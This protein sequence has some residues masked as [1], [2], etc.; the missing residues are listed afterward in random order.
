MGGTNVGTKDNCIELGLEMARL[1]YATSE[2]LEKSLPPV[3]TS[4]D[5][6]AEK[7]TMAGLLV[8]VSTIVVMSV[9]RQHGGGPQYA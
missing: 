6:P 9:K 5:N 8:L 3:G 4:V 1:S 7:T 2:R